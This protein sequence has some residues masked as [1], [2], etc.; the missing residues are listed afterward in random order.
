[1][2]SKKKFKQ[3]KTEWVKQNFTGQKNKLM[4]LN[5]VNPEVPISGRLAKLLML[6]KGWNKQREGLL[7]IGLSFK[8]CS[9]QKLCNFEILH[10]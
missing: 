5:M 8:V 2:S 7:P 9:S 1:M 6:T 3:F 10:Y 4:L